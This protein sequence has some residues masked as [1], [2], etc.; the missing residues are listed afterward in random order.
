MDVVTVGLDRL[1]HED[2]TL[3]RDYV[4]AD[5]RLLTVI[6]TDNKFDDQRLA[7][8]VGWLMGNGYPI[9]EIESLFE[10]VDL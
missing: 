3:N 1:M 4:E 10:E 9:D 5:D 2:P 6:D 7:F 8:I